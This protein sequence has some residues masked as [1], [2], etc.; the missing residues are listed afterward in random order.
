M[1]T[2]ASLLEDSPSASAAPAVAR[3]AR[4]T[5]V[6]LTV[7]HSNGAI[8]L[9][10]VNLTIEPGQ[11]TAVIGPSGAGK[12]TLLAALA[13]ITPIP[14][15]GVTFYSV[16]GSGENAAVGFVPQDDVLHGELPLRR[17]LRYAAALRM[18]AP[19]AVID[20]A[21]DDAMTTLGL[22]TRGE[23]P[24]HS[25]SGGERKRAN[26]A[27]EIFTRPAVC[28][29]D[30][31]TS[32]LDPSAATEL[33]DYMRRMAASGSTVVFTT[34]SVEDIERSH[35]VVVIA[36]GGRLV[37]TGTPA[38]VL[39]RVGA[40]SFPELYAM[41]TGAHAGTTAGRGVTAT[42]RRQQMSTRHREVRTDRP[43]AMR[44]WWTLTRRSADIITRNRLTVA[45][46][47]GSPAA[48]IAMFVVLFKPG[49]FDPGAADPAAA[50][51]VAY[52][53]SFAGFF[54]GLTFGLLQVTTELAMLRSERY[55]GVRVGAYLASKVALLT[56]VLLLV[57]AT[58]IV[59]LEALD[60]IP[61]LSAAGFV[62]LNITM[63]LNA[64]AALCLGLLA[65]AAVTS[66]AQAALA[67]PMLCFPAVLFSGAM[68]P[69]PVMAGV[70]R[71]ISAAM[72]DRWAFEAIARHLHVTDRLGPSSPYAGLG[73]SPRAVYWMLLAGFAVVTAVGAYA[74]IHHRAGGGGR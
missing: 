59:V 67:L 16:G 66:T 48:V 64:I 45:I 74:A 62:E 52:W 7:R 26:I 57:N 6:D 60:R 51:Q 35:H 43:G 56:P 2:H 39:E 27:T 58:M 8:G 13:G 25:L 15:E 47:L 21:V 37:A 53:L 33:V 54:F 10:D 72:S 30:E 29:L 20:A 41:L 36:P 3:G 46:L 70:G 31:P 12:S 65:S 42:G 69:N 44:Q 68:V 28:F 24:V 50:V 55:A 40:A 18:A 14:T 5:A 34:H 49:G 9:D 61:H 22:T 11:L 4:I 1:N 63:G 38:E 19:A 73:A 71:A 32:G 23:T 17:T